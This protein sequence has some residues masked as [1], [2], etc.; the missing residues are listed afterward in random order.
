MVLKNR[1][2][3]QSVH[4]CTAD[5]RTDWAY[6]LPGDGSTHFKHKVYTYTVMP[7]GS[8][9]AQVWEDSVILN[10]MHEDKQISSSRKED[11]V[12]TSAPIGAWMCRLW[13]TGQQTGGE[14][15]RR[16]H[17]KATPAM[18]VIHTFLLRD[19]YL[20]CHQR[21][22]KQHLD[23]IQRRSLACTFSPENKILVK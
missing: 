13:Q 19:R 11:Y 20:Y 23:S 14:T 7:G 4:R 8:W 17:R 22:S 6:S 2:L 18:I 10:I 12:L 3:Y 9:R 15:D 1:V 5:L 16:V 21:T